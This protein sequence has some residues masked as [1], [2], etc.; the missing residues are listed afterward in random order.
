MRYFGLHYIA[1]YMARDN[2]SFLDTLYKNG[3][4]WAKGENFPDIDE[5]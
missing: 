3:F 5:T 4:I 1:N 2:T